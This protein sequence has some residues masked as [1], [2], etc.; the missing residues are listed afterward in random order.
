MSAQQ[1][2]GPTPDEILAK[3]ATVV[4]KDCAGADVSVFIRMLPVS[5]YPEYILVMEDEERAVDLFAGKPGLAETLP[6]ASIGKIVDEGERLNTDFFPWFV[7]RLRRLERVD[8]NGL[9]RSIAVSTNTSQG[10][11][12][13]AA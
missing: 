2:P 8:P 6:P 4:V 11:V 3:G 13:A 5:A 9:R 1:F 7:R 10:S 12:S